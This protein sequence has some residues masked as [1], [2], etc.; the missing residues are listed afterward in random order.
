MQRT[1]NTD[2]VAVESRTGTA[3]YM[4]R[5]EKWIAPDEVA[6]M[7]PSFLDAGI[8][9]S[10]GSVLITQTVCSRGSQKL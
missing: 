5:H 1:S 10:S 7:H 3:M 2:T 4:K 6:H 8:K 9:G